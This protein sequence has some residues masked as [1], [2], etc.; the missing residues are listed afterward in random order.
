MI[1]SIS[2]KNK[3]SKEL[4]KYLKN[5]SYKDDSNINDLFV[6]C[7]KL[8]I[9]G[10]KRENEEDFQQ[11]KKV[12][13]INAYNNISLV[14][15]NNMIINESEIMK[16][17]KKQEINYFE[18][19]SINKEKQLA[20]L[21]SQISSKNSEKKFDYRVLSGPLFTTKFHQY[22]KG[23][24]IKDKEYFEILTNEVN[25]RK[26]KYNEEKNAKHNK[27]HHNHTNNNNKEQ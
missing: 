3:S 14:K 11:K 21:N 13:K 20:H 9:G 2:I 19:N 10:F 22:H 4:N 6:L 5:I 25:A 18:K 23:Y 1:Q 7:K 15:T 16:S 24:L 8:I 26:K 27:N 12:K 17:E